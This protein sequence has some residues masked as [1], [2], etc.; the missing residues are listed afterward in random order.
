MRLQE[1]AC[2]VR[3][4]SWDSQSRAGRHNPAKVALMGGGR[5]HVLPVGDSDDWTIYREVGDQSS[6]IYV[7]S[8]NR[9]LGYCGAQGYDREDQEP[10]DELSV[11]LQSDEQVRE[12]VGDLGD[13]SDRT[14]ARRLIELLSQVVA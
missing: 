12:S 1:L 5:R 8:I 11:F 14:I 2:E 7:V 3:R 13:L 9:G 4:E 10:R 6:R